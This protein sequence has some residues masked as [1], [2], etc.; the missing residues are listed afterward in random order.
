V[1]KFCVY[2]RAKIDD[3]KGMKGW[4]NEWYCDAD[5][6]RREY[7]NDDEYPEVADEDEN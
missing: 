1:D 6:E 7:P 5:C 3:G 2:C 4:D